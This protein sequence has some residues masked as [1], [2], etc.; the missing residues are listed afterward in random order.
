MREKNNFEGK[1]HNKSKNQTKWNSDS[2][3]DPSPPYFPSKMTKT[4]KKAD[5]SNCLVVTV[6]DDDKENTL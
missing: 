4:K 5:F 3:W 1:S 2:D 6:E